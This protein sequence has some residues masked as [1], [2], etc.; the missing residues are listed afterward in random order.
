MTIRQIIGA[1]VL[2]LMLGLEP[3]SVHAAE[4]VPF[5]FTVLTPKDHPEYIRVRRRGQHGYHWVFV[6][7][8]KTV[9]RYV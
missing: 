8:H 1:A 7:R 9:W 2:L 6:R 4:Y 3:P 5:R